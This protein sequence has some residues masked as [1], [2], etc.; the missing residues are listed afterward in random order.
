MLEGAGGEPETLQVVVYRSRE[1]EFGLVVDEILDIVDE[2]IGTPHPSSRPG[3]LGSAV[4]GGKVT[5]FLDVEAV[6]RWA[7]LSS[8]EGL[9]RLRQ[10]LDGERV[11]QTVEEVRR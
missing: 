2:T 8:P 11:E 5:D 7:A 4:V 3:L 1:G 6:A 9:E 10:A